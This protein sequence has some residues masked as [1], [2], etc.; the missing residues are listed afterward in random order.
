MQLALPAIAQR[1]LPLVMRAWNIGDALVAGQW[2]IREPSADAPDVFP[3]V[4]LV[5]L[6]AF[7]RRGNR[8]GYGA[9]YY[10]RT[11]EAARTR[12]VVITIGVAFA[13]QERDDVPVTQY[14]R[15]ID[16]VMTE[17]D[18]IACARA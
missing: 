13:A 10:D 16:F 12:K 6:A 3:D 8:L 2:N 14:D 7:D 15:R 11:I 17:I 9:G 5:P 18:T 1:G 4:M